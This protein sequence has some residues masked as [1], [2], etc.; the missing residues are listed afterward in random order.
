MFVT[1]VCNTL[2]QWNLSAGFRI[3]HNGPTEHHELTISRQSICIAHLQLLMLGARCKAVSIVPGR[4]R[5]GLRLFSAFFVFMVVRIHYGSEHSNKD[6]QYRRVRTTSTLHKRQRTKRLAMFSRAF[7]RARC[8]RFAVRK[9]CRFI[10]A[11]ADEPMA[12][13]E[14]FLI[15]SWTH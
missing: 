4:F 1:S 11:M 13:S 14:R 5:R 12:K 3:Y 9:S 2:V 6:G 7:L 10:V 15:G 8:M